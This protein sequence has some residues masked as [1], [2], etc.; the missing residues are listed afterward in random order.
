[1]D[2]KNTKNQKR[3]QLSSILTISIAHMIHDIYIS[4]LAPILPLLIEKL[5]ISYSMAGFLSVVQ[6]LPSLLDPFVGIIADRKG[7]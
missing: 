7:K 1:M 6:R 4:F 3:F 5:G 2:L